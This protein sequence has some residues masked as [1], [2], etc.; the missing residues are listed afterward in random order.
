VAERNKVIP[1]ADHVA[2]VVDGELVA[3]NSERYSAV[4]DIFH[5]AQSLIQSQAIGKAT[6]VQIVWAKW[7][8]IQTSIDAEAIAAYAAEQGRVFRKRFA[9][10]LGPITEHR[11][12]ARPA[13]V[14]SGSLPYGSGCDALL[15]L[16]AQ[17]YRDESIAYQKGAAQQPIQRAVDRFI[18]SAEQSL[19]S[20]T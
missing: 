8:L 10:K 3:A 12:A 4:A 1:R 15:K 18:D 19:L 5:L 17:P 20:A 6:S 13:H 14:S 2:F 9:S 11:I 16:W 7:D